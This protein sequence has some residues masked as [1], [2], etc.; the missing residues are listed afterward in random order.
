MGFSLEPNNQGM[1][2]CLLKRHFAVRFLNGNAREVCL[3]E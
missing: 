2:I 1:D 3:G